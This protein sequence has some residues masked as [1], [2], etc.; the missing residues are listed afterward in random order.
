MA[1]PAEVAPN[2]YSVLFENDRVRLLEVRL[3]PGDGSARHSHPDHLVY[4]LEG[5]KVRLTSPDGESAEVDVSAGDVM[6][7]EAE[8]HSTGNTGTTELRA[9]FFELK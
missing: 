1:D 7:R 6:W 2:V 9:L 3:R 8:V 5:G 4:A